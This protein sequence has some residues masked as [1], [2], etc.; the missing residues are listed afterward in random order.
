MD[1]WFHHPRARFQS[2]FQGVAASVKRAWNL[3]RSS[4]LDQF[5]INRCWHARRNAPRKHRGAKLSGSN[6]QPELLL[7]RGQLGFGNVWPGLV[8][9]GLRSRNRVHYRNT[10]P[11]F[12]PGLHEI[13]FNSFGFQRARYKLSVESAEE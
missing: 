11:R 12:L 9:L 8:D 10:D 2:L 13:R 3:G 5:S 7:K 6:K 1:V 4:I